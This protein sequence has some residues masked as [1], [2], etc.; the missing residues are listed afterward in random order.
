MLEIH[1]ISGKSILVNMTYDEVHEMMEDD[2]DYIMV[3][4]IGKLTGSLKG[5]INKDYIEMID[6][7]KGDD[8]Y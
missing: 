4:R 3:T 7:L 1:L 2:L 8:I 5:I 6:I